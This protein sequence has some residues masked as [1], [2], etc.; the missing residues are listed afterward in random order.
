DKR[1]MA[2]AGNPANEN[3]AHIY[4]W[5]H[6]K[7]DIN[8]LT[9]ILE[10]EKPA[11]ERRIWYAY[12]NQSSIIFEGDGR[13][14]TVVARVLQDANPQTGQPQVAQVWSAEYNTQGHATKLADPR[15]RQTT[16]T[17]AANDIDLAQVKQTTGAQNDVLATYTVSTN[18][19][20][21]TI[22]DAANKTTSFT[23]NLRGQLLTA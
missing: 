4:H 7:G 8:T 22:T 23:Y 10:S 1:A 3:A 14:P 18:H 21:L 16:F 2:V 5:L 15:G 6:L 20:P 11:L 19:R 17:Y 12:P 13:R 9:S